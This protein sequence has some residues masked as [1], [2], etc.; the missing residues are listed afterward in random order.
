MTMAASPLLAATATQEITGML[1]GFYEW[2]LPHAQAG[3]KMSDRRMLEYVTDRLQAR[4]ARLSEAKEGEIAQL[5]Y[6]PFVNAQDFATGWEKNIS[7]RDVKVKGDAATATV[8]LSGEFNSTIHL[9]LVRA[10]GKWKIDNF[11]PKI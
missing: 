1:R 6:D 8:L 5:D 9:R 7:V 10:S 4:I 3:G 2:Y 11:T